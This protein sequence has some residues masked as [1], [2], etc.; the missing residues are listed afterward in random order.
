MSRRYFIGTSNFDAIDF[1]AGAIIAGIGQDVV[2][3]VDETNKRSDNPKVDRFD[4]R[5]SL[6]I[7]KKFSRSPDGF[8]RQEV[9][10]IS[11]LLNAENLYLFLNQRDAKTLTMEPF[12]SRL[13]EL[14]NR[15]NALRKKGAQPNAAFLEACANALG[16]RPNVR[17]RQTRRISGQKLQQFE[18]LL[19][20]KAR[21]CSPSVFKLRQGGA[22]VI[23]C[24][25][26]DIVEL[27]SDGATWLSSSDAPLEP[28]V[29]FDT[30]VELELEGPVDAI[31]PSFEGF[32]QGH[33]PWYMPYEDAVDQNDT[34]RAISVVKSL[35]SKQSTDEE[36]QLR[37][38]GLALLD[39]F[40]M[41]DLPKFLH[42]S[43]L[44][45]YRWIFNVARDLSRINTTT[46][47]RWAWS[48]RAAKRI[49]KSLSSRYRPHISESPYL[50]LI[51]RLQEVEEIAKSYYGGDSQSANKIY[52]VGFLL[53]EELEFWTLFLIDT[54][55]G[56]NYR[57]ASKFNLSDLE[58][59]F[60][61]SDKSIEKRYIS[62]VRFFYTQIALI[63][64]SAILLISDTTCRA[65]IP[66]LA[67]ISNPG[68]FQRFIEHNRA[69]ITR[70][71]AQEKK[72]ICL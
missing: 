12:L 17:V 34:P 16:T 48:Q 25:K 57:G 51:L 71:I 21:N 15:A 40:A 1:V 63:S 8:V 24:R 29:S 49:F 62:D 42:V 23:G 31:T 5:Q 60:R 11:S 64:T 61:S 18:H 47:E 70:R 41:S 33:C 67:M 7:P 22:I 13:T 56:E 44:S 20:T 54:G 6:P 50:R 58:K 52:E 19:H 26:Y 43:G 10:Q 14:V 55:L 69:F 35:F 9:I 32:I 39:E 27:K 37:E 30:I 36:V 28:S 2:L 68:E 46:D 38:R 53:F 45:E 3:E 65:T 72:L 4:F 66:S 59:K